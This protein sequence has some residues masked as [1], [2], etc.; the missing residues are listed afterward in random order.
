MTIAIETILLWVAVLILVSVLASKLSDRYAVPALL[1]FLGIGILAGSEGVGGIY[2]ND[3]WTAKSTGILAL[4]FIIFSGG[5]NTTWKSVRPL[6]LPGLLLSTMGVLMTAIVVGLFAMSILKFSLFE[7]LLL[8]AIVSSTDASAVF[9]VLRLRKISLKGH[10]KP[11]LELESGSN[12]PMAVFLTIGF[13]EIITS[14][15]SSV[16]NLLPLFVLDMGIGLVMGYL[17]A[18]ASIV[19]INKIKLEYEGLYPVL[20]I[21]LV[22]LTYALTTSLRGN[23]FLAVYLLGL[24]MSRSDFVNKR[25]LVRFH[26]G[27]G[28]LMQIAMFLTLGLLVVPSQIMPVIKSGLLIAAVLIF[29]ARPV[30]V[31]LCLMPFKFRFAEKIMVSWVGLR[32]AVPIILATFPLLAGITQA[33]T[34]FNVVFFV[35]LASVLVQGTSIPFVSRLLGVNAPFDSRKRYPIEFEQTGGIDASLTDM[36]VPYDSSVVG[37]KI[38]QIKIPLKALIV[39]IS[40]GD[41]FIVPNGSTVIE[42]GDVF[43]VLAND[44]D[45]KSLQRTLATLGNPQNSNLEAY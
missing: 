31:F 30:S 6:F 23:G 32:G 28:W 4:I 33:H 43:L 5:L 45:F 2:F 14:R 8:G 22:L 40:R 25:L 18:R 16:I 37:S 36:I 10:L 39:L 38:A 1:L 29:L 15:V 19:L 13:L 34:I 35:A 12:D 26:E 41:K 17:I 24:M 44:H 9:S 11:L 7:G 21:A 3:Y 42:G 27:L 20:T